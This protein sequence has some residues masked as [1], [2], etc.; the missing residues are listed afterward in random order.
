MLFS[1][2]QQFYRSTLYITEDPKVYC[3]ALNFLVYYNQ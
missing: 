2:G 3:F 1:L